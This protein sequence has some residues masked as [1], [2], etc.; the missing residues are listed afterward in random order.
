MTAPGNSGSSIHGVYRYRPGS[1]IA[2][3][4]ISNFP[5]APSG[6]VYRVWASYRG[7]WNSLGEMRP[8]ASGHA[9]QIAEQP[10]LA[11]AP[12]AVEVTLELSIGGATPRG[13]ILIHWP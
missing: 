10:A 3:V 6:H 12:D 8:D 13:P 9:R 1:P 7:V 5:P 4:T 2:V 11:A